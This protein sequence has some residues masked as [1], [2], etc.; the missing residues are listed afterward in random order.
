[1]TSMSRTE[2]AALC[3]LALQLGEDQPTL[4]GDWTIK[5]LVVHLLIREGSA[6]SVG[7][8]V[9]QL[10]RVTDVASRRLGRNDFT[11]LVERLRSGPPFYSP[12]RVPKFEKAA[13]TI[14]FFIHHEDI[15]RAQPSWE[16]RELTARQESALWKLVGHLGKALVRSADGGVIIERSD[17]GQRAT[18]KKG[19]PSVVVHGLPSELTLYV[20]GR[21]DQARVELDGSVAATDALD[22]SNLGI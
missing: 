16:P 3:D 15:R 5:D 8:T 13:N 17:T 1:M 21:Q 22:A 11:V 9:P 6:A 14:E 10:E 20:Y 4:S 19:E 7:I 18:L 2:R 12:L